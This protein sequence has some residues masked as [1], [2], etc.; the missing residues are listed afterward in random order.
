MPAPS[1]CSEPLQTLLSEQ[2]VP[3]AAGVCATP[4]IGS[5]ESAVHG[6][7]SSIVS[8]VPAAQRPPPSQSSVPL[9]TFA[10]AQEEPFGV[11]VW[12]T[13]EAGSH[14]S[15]VQGLPSSIVGGALA[16]HAPEALHVSLPLQALPSEQD[17][18]VA[19]GVCRTP[20][21]GS[22]ESAVHGLPSSTV[23]AAPD[24]QAP[25]E[26]ISAP[27]QALPSEH[28]VPFATAICVTP[29]AGSQA[30]AV[31]GLP[32]SSAGGVPGAHAPAW[33]SSLPLQAFPSEHDVPLSG[34]CTTPSTGSHESAVHGLP[35]SS[36]GALP[37]AHV[38]L[39]LQVSAPLHALPSEQE[40]PAATGACTTPRVGSQLSLVHALPSSVEGGVPATQAPLALQ[41]SAPLQ[42]FPSEH[43]APAA[44]GL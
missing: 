23:G 13:P 28:D 36:A 29:A 26:H 35:S 32:S 15:A 1:H 21:F 33:H 22:H 6:L 4:A 7:P 41:V 30:S 3:A 37:G 38:P 9:Q 40:V 39:A 5:H 42:A 18:P 31:H 17:V 20:V 2:L 34:K 14:A 44:A 8:G 25:L 19:T 12:L 16:T 11:G 27:L 10:S 24:A 43:D